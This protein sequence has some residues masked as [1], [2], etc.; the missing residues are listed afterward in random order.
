H[1]QFPAHTALVSCLAVSSAA[2]S[3]IPVAGTARRFLA[4]V[5]RVAHDPSSIPVDI[6]ILACRIP[7]GKTCLSRFCNHDPC[8]RSGKRHLGRILECEAEGHFAALSTRGIKVATK[9]LRF[10]TRTRGS[11]RSISH[12]RFSVLPFCIA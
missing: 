2:T 1:C 7:P 10:R 6:F 9:R 12:V 4:L 5:V 3:S 8:A 11:N